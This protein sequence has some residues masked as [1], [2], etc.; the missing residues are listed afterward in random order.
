MALALVPVAFFAAAVQLGAA[1]NDSTLETVGRDA[2]RGITVAQDIKLN[3]AELDE[4]VVQR[5]L[6]PAELSE[7]GFP[8]DYDD[9]REELH[10]NLVAAAAESSTGAAYRQPLIN[11]EYALSHYHTLVR[12]AFAAH[13]R[14][15]IAEAALLYGEAHDVVDG[16]LLSEADFV[17]KANTYV[18]NDAY[19]TQT[20]RSAGTSQLILVSCVVLVVFL[21]VLQLVLAR[22]FRRLLNAALLAATVIAAASGAFALSRL[23]TS[24]DA[25]TSAREQAFDSVHVLA[26]ARA[27]VVS[28]RQAEGQLL[29]D[30]SRAPDALENFQAQARRVFRVQEGDV[31]AVATA[32]DIPEGAGGFLA[33]VVTGDSAESREATQSSV[34]AFG[35]FL[36]AD[37]ALRD[38]VA[39]GDVAGAT[40]AY[41]EGE[42]FTALTDAVDDAQDINQSVFDR[43]VSDSTDAAALIGPVSLI[44]A[45]AIFLLVVVG[46][47][48]RLREYRT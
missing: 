39:D 37:T 4:I 27:T 26:R 30:P 10:D 32:G 40:A 36:T 13:A 41:E 44:A 31:A 47:Y 20:S 18:L 23:N 38:Q 9:K 3:I 28:A 24:A 15:D 6:E 43:H 16:T 46:L 25:L 17:D 35:G 19:D 1:R 21:V 29:L 2:T 34:R 12:D 11:I 5:L 48:Q 42:A 45:G 7:A 14:G 8:T 33:R 22:K